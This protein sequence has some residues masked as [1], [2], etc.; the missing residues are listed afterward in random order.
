ITLND[1]VSNS[2][3]SLLRS[4]VSSSD[5]EVLLASWIHRTDHFRIEDQVNPNSMGLEALEHDSTTI[6]READNGKCKGPLPLGVSIIDK[7]C[8]IFGHIFPSVHDK[9]RAQLLNHFNECIKQAK[10]SRQ[11]AIQVNTV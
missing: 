5:D 3:S 9:H 7:S 8:L 4:L 6:Y 1:S 11:E 10:A 2:T